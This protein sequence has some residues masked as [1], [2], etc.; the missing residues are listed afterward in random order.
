MA[1]SETDVKAE[2]K[3]ASGAAKTSLMRRGE[4]LLDA[5]LRLLSSVRFGI[6]ML[7]ILLVCSMIGMLIMQVDVEGFQEYFAKLT[8][9]QKLIYTNLRFF[10]IYHS[11]YFTF[12]LSITA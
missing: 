12:L 11:W 2:S 9:A 5:V 3:T 7:A 1:I 4:W 10:N 6:V 8:P